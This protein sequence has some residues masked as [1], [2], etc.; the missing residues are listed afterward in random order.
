MGTGWWNPVPVVTHATKARNSIKS[1]TWDYRPDFAEGP[2]GADQVL[3]EAIIGIGIKV[4]KCRQG[5]LELLRIRRSNNVAGRRRR[6]GPAD[7][8]NRT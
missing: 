4:D 6:H 8:K 7:Q 3:I 2:A 1:W 5:G